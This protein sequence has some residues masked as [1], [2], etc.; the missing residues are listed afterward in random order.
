MPQTAAH[1]ATAP[2]P[3]TVDPFAFVSWSAGDR[4]RSQAR[5]HRPC[6]DPPPPAH[7]RPHPCG[8]PGGGHPVPPATHTHVLLATPP[9]RNRGSAVGCALPTPQ[10]PQRHTG[11][12][13]S[14]RRNPP[15][16]H[17]RGVAQLP[18]AI[19]QR[20]HARHGDVTRLTQPA[21]APRSQAR[22]AAAAAAAA[23]AAAAVEPPPPPHSKALPQNDL[24]K[25]AQRQTPATRQ[26]R[27]RQSQS[28][29]H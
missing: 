6:S 7:L 20:T 12:P 8:A 18:K 28:G 15:P 21:A 1:T 13:P 11:G 4:Y 23:T 16:P 29:A 24:D 2:K 17:E 5:H 9:P 25:R 14:H 22:S 26:P 3:R 10:Q 19:R 27:R